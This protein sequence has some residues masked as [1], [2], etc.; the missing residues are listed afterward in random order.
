MADPRFKPGDTVRA[1]REGKL[2]MSVVEVEPDAGQ[3]TV[4]AGLATPESRASVANAPRANMYRCQPLGDARSHG[5]GTSARW[6]REDDL[7]EA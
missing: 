7:V 4:A 5:R 1:K 6:F 3:F 2:V